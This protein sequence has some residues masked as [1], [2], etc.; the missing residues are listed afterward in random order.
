MKRDGGAVTLQRCGLAGERHRQ[1]S[2]A[3]MSRTIVALS[4]ESGLG[5][6]TLCETLFESQPASSAS[7]VGI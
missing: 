6:G 1:R 2:S 3:T 5:A 4:I 7:V